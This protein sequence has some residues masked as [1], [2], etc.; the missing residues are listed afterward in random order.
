MMKNI[1]LSYSRRDLRLAEEL[2]QALLGQGYRPWIGVNPGRGPDWRLEIDDAIQ[3]ADAL[4]VAVTAAAANSLYVTYEW[5]YAMG[6]G[7]P[8]FAIVFQAASVH[9]RLLAVETYDIRDWPDENH[10]WDYFLREFNRQMQQRPASRQSIHPPEAETLDYDRSVMPR[11]PGYWLVIRRGPMLNQMFRLDKDIV[12]LGRDA[13]NDILIKDPE[14][15]RYHLRLLKRGDV[16]LLE[17]LGSVN[18]ARINGRR[19]AGRARLNDG[20][21]IMLGDGIGLSYHLVYGR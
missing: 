15:S 11:R 1:F 5:A 21:V 18:G 3:N 8:V 10:F 6:L 9:P 4:I 19:T 20:D 13:V 16:Y 7:A 14:V 17:D 2:R 12:S